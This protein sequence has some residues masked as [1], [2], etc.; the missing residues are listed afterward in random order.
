MSSRAARATAG[1]VPFATQPSTNFSFS[2]AI[3]AWFFLPIALRR[4]SA[5]AAREARELLR[6]LHRL[7]LVH[8]DRVRGAR[9]RLEPRVD[10]A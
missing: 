3:R 8:R 2:E 1:V 4:S 9:D 7:L 5:S 10:E 6:D